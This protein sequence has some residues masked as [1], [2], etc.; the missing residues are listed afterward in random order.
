MVHSYVR[1][2]DG[3][4]HRILNVEGDY[5]HRDTM[6]Q[7][8]KKHFNEAAHMLVPADPKRATET[9]DVHVHGIS[10]DG[11]WEFIKQ[12]QYT[13][14]ANGIKGSVLVQFTGADETFYF[15]LLLVALRLRAEYD[16]ECEDGLPDV[17]FLVS[18]EQCMYITQWLKALTPIQQEAVLPIHLIAFRKLLTGQMPV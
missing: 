6:I 8:K 1:E 11:V 17:R 14:K 2:V 3:T 16:T 15:K 18:E 4:I 7:L 13:G 9:K 10:T 12:E 5:S